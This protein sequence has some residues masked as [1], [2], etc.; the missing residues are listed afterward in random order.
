MSP[1]VR[2]EDR[3]DDEEEWGEDAEEFNSSADDED[4]D[5]TMPCPYCGW[6]IPED[7]PR[8]PYCEHYLSDEDS[9][10]PR[11]PLWIIVGTVACLYIIYRWIAG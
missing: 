11:K 10:P 5:P 1:Q 4:E 8:C 7:T 2:E 6:H 9:P 3:Y